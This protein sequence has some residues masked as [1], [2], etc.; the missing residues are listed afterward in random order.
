[1][2]GHAASCIYQLHRIATI[3]LSANMDVQEETADRMLD[4]SAMSEVLEDMDRTEP[5]AV[6]PRS[7]GLNNS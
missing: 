4:R 3:T 7:V 6:S 1:M 2:D 5:L